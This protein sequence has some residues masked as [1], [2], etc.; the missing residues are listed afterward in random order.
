MAGLFSSTQENKIIS[1]AA[2]V[3]ADSVDNRKTR[4][5]FPTISI[6][7]ILR[8][9]V[10]VARWRLVRSITNE[11]VP[12]WTEMQTHLCGQW[13]SKSCATRKAICEWGR[14]SIY[15]CVRDMLMLE[16]ARFRSENS[17]LGTEVV[18]G[19]WMMMSIGICNSIP[20][21]VREFAHRRSKHMKEGWAAHGT[22]YA[23]LFD[24]QRQKVE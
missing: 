3:A 14:T 13:M 2:A 15:V 21:T 6:C 10:S 18:V 20:F 1:F 9:S 11:W 5:Q 19:W 7:F 16:L 4:S 17:K 22:I 12:L 23:F 24:A 8:V